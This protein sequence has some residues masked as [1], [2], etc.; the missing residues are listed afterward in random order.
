MF[1]RN[2]QIEIETLDGTLRAVL[3]LAP[4][5]GLLLQDPHT[6]VATLDP[7]RSFGPSAF[8][9]LH[10]RAIFPTTPHKS[11]DAAL[12]AEP[13]SD[14]LPLATLVRLPTITG[15]NCPADPDAPCTLT[16]T[17]FYLIESVSPDPAYTTSTPVPDGYTGTTLTIPHPVASTLFLHLRDDPA[18]V[19][20]ANLPAPPAAATPAAHAHGSKSGAKASTRAP[21]SSSHQTELPSVAATPTPATK[22]AP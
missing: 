16:G 10:L 2:G 22:A 12:D 6:I 9:S 1:P 21:A 15:L 18:P 13:A 17:N 4:S 11:D 19:D 3:T 20:S 7:D 14:W 5:G 8:G